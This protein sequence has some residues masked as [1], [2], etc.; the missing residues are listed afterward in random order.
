MV[1]MIAYMTH[2]FD[3]LIGQSIYPVLSHFICKIAAL[4]TAAQSI[5]SK[6][7]Y[8][9]LANGF[10]FVSFHLNNSPF[11]IG[12]F[13]NWSTVFLHSDWGIYYPPPF[14]EFNILHLNQPLDYYPQWIIYR[15]ACHGAENSTEG[16]F[17]WYVRKF[18]STLFIPLKYISRLTHY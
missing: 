12:L 6:N 14:D 18:A 3:E 7:V 2:I 8:K 11:A 9:I 4:R 17:N 16:R 1:A 15:T 5:T 13:A 10:L